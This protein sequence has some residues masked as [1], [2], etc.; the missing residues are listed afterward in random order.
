M[1]IETDVKGDTLY[2]RID[3][4]VDTGGGAEL[5]AR[6]GE[7]LENS[8]IKNAEFDLRDVPMINSAGIGKIL[9]FHK[10]FEKNGGGLRIKGISA[11]LKQQFQEIHLD[12]I[13][14]ME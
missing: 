2:C 9:K 5:S 7:F 1:T 4:A 12:Q 3:G 8:E 13:L 14:S 6:L 11:P 10:H